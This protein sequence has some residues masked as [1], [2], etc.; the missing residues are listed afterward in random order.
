MQVSRSSNGRKCHE[1]IRRWVVWLMENHCFSPNEFDRPFDSDTNIKSYISCPGTLEGGVNESSEFKNILRFTPSQRGSRM[2]VQVMAELIFKTFGGELVRFCHFGTEPCIIEKVVEKLLGMKV[3]LRPV[4]RSSPIYDSKKHIEKLGLQREL[5]GLCRQ[6]YDK[7]DTFLKLGVWKTSGGAIGSEGG[8]VNMW[9]L[10]TAASLVGCN[11][12]HCKSSSRIAQSLLSLILESAPSSSTPGNVVPVRSFHEVSRE[13]ECVRVRSDGRPENFL[14][15]IDDGNFAI[16][17]VFSYCPVE[18]GEMPEDFLGCG[19]VREM[20]KFLKCKYH[21]VPP[22]H[23]HGNYQLVPGRFH[24]IY[25]KERDIWGS[26]LVGKTGVHVEYSDHS[27]MTWGFDDWEDNLREQSFLVMPTI[28]RSGAVVRLGVQDGSVGCLVSDGMCASLEEQ[29]GNVE[30]LGF[31]S[32]F[33]HIKLCYHA[34]VTEDE[35]VPLQVLD[36]LKQLIP[37]GQHLWVK[38]NTDAWNRLQD[39]FPPLAEAEAEG[40]SPCVDERLLR[41]RL[42][43]PL[44]CNPVPGKVYVTVMQRSERALHSLDFSYTHICVDPWELTAFPP[45]G[46]DMQVKELVC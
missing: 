43:V 25:S 19:Y 18:D 9:C 38:P 30:D 34:R 16:N 33:D 10:L 12:I 11:H 32:N 5:P 6:G 39:K 7:P 3:D 45:L 13:A 17:G 42:N 4:M 2:G 40:G 1:S 31:M 23:V 22:Q 24:C 14:R 28:W 41:V 20:A 27:A 44:T 21:D 35:L 37:P 26:L 15:P 36:T 46:D 29:G 8:C